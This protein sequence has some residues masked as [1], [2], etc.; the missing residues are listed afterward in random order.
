LKITKVILILISVNTLLYSQSILYKKNVDSLNRNSCVELSVKINEIVVINQNLK[1]L[2]EDESYFDVFD[3]LSDVDPIVILDNDVSAQ[4]LKTKYETLKR[5][6]YAS[7]NFNEHRLSQKIEKLL[8]QLVDVCPEL[9][10]NDLMAK[11][12]PKIIDA[13][14]L[15]KF[16]EEYSFYLFSMNLNQNSTLNSIDEILKISLSKVVYLP[17]LKKEI[18]N[19]ESYKI[20]VTE[21]AKFIKMAIFD[22]QILYFFNYR[23]PDSVRQKSSIDTVCIFDYYPLHQWKEP[24][25]ITY[26]INPE[27]ALGLLYYNNL[28]RILE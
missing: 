26:M 23:I 9:L 6:C 21:G 7:R 27:D 8:L 3:S 20:V 12:N 13:T 24:V 19:V 10:L 14:S 28:N 2:L 17:A 11:N 18:E 5:V 25:F 16:L 15:K 22:S 1:N 4:N